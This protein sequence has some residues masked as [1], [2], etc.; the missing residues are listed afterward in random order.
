MTKSPELQCPRLE[1]HVRS[2]GTAQL[3]ED[4]SGHRRAATRAARGSPRTRAHRPA[5]RPDDV[6]GLHGRARRA[7]RRTT[8]LR[9]GSATH[10]VQTARAMER[11]EAVMEIERPDLVIVPGD[12]NSTLAATLVAAKLG[13]P[14]AHVE[15]GLRSFDRTMP[16]EIN[17]I[18][19]DEFSDSP[20]HPLRRGAREPAGRGDRARPHPLRRQ[21]DDRHARGD[22]GSVPWARRRVAATG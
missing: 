21:H 22:G 9:V 16:E 5:L 7:C 14:L 6:V 10:A 18:V 2:R 1:G 13:I 3:R 19:A 11:I 12:V 4:G 8:C 17:R 20:V 15:A